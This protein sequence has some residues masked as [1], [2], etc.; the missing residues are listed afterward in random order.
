MSMA[1]ALKENRGVRGMETAERPRHCAIYSLSVRCTTEGGK[2]IGAVKMRDITD[3]K[4][5]EQQAL[6]V[7][8]CIT[9]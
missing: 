2:L 5:A 9:A 7:P 4:R 3:R 8:S 6:L 1:V